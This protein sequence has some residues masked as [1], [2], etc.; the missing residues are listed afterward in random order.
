MT[1]IEALLSNLMLINTF[2]I[3]FIINF[4]NSL[5]YQDLVDLDKRFFTTWPASTTVWDIDAP[6]SVN[7]VIIISQVLCMRCWTSLIC[8]S[9][10]MF[11][12]VGLIVGFYNSECKYDYD[13]FKYWIVPARFLIFTAYALFLTGSIFLYGATTVFSYGNFPKYC[14]LKYMTLGVYADINSVYNSTSGDIIEGCVDANIVNY[15]GGNYQT[16]INTVGSIMVVVVFLSSHFMRYFLTLFS[17]GNKFIDGD[18]QR[19]TEGE[20]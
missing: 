10:S 11:I 15:Q 18:V 14:Q 6:E 17:T 8:L 7:D 2:T 20:L 3:G 5:N 16:T 12:S 4:I 9:I 1:E 19:S 13:V